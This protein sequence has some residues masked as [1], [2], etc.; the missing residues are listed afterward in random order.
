MRKQHCLKAATGA[1]RARI[2]A[3]KLLVQFFVAM[4]DALA[5]LD[6]RFGREP[7]APLTGALERSAADRSC[8]V[9]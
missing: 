6:V 1:A 8:D 7:L 3:P 4:Y 5:A 2:V 9:A